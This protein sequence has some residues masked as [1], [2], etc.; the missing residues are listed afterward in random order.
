MRTAI[1]LHG[2]SSLN[3]DPAEA[4]DYW[5][6][7]EPAMGMSNSN[8][9]PWLQGELCRRDI[10]TQTPEMP[11]PYRG[12]INYTEWENTFRQFE[13][14][15]DTILIGFSTGAGFLL[16][17]LSQNP[18]IRAGRLVLVAPNIDPENWLGNFMQTNYDN[19]L[20]DRMGRIDIVYSTD[21]RQFILDSVKRIREIYPT[22][23]IHE[24]KDKGH[25]TLSKIGTEFPELLEIIAQ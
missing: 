4:R 13:I 10:L 19:N 11:Y 12:R 18:E 15:P 16:K 20:L 9:I 8:W 23:N 5:L 2:T 3:E 22:A 7:R 6:T 21:D 1:T 24:F 14:K 25:F 17:Y